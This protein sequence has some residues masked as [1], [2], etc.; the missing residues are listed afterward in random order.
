MDIERNVKNKS[1]TADIE[2]IGFLLLKSAKSKDIAACSGSG[3][4]YRGT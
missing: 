1:E 2:R 3:S 4:A